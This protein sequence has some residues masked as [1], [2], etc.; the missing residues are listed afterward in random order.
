MLNA[1]DG[2]DDTFA[3]TDGSIEGCSVYAAGSTRTSNA[4]LDHSFVGCDRWEHEWAAAAS[5]GGA[6]VAL[7]VLGAWDVFDLQ[8][9]EGNNL[10][11]GTPERDDTS[12]VR[13]AP[14]SPHWSRRG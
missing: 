9:A 2:I 1:P 12:P 8:D 7:V 10:T 6:S 11:F 13:C 3:I 4:A 14:A 5:K